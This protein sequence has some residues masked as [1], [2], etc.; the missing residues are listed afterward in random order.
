MLEMLVIDINS[1]IGKLHV[2]KL[3]VTQNSLVILMEFVCPD[4]VG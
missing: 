4:T 3:R 1:L 2:S